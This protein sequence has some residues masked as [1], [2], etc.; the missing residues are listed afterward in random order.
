MRTDFNPGSTLSMLAAM[1]G[2]TQQASIAF[3]DLLQVYANIEYSAPLCSVSNGI[4][5]L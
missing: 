1:F 4:G 5:G 3:V 2:S